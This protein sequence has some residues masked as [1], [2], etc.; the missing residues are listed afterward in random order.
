LGQQKKK[1]RKSINPFFVGGAFLDWCVKQ[2]WL[3]QEG[4]QYFA[5]EEGA[6]QLQQRFEIAVKG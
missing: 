3:V 1:R 6:R 5:T 2:G 4:R